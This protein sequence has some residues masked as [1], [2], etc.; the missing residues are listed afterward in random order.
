VFAFL[1]VYLTFISPF[2][3]MLSV[4]RV[5]GWNRMMIE[6]SF[7]FLLRDELIPKGNASSVPIWVESWTAM[8]AVMKVQ[9]FQFIVL[10]GLVGS[11]PWTAIVFF[12]LWFEL[13]G[14]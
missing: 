10:Q 12:T 9:T 3:V 7:F 14:E 13:I 8:K 6:N 4:L 11:I 5:L 1:N 2:H